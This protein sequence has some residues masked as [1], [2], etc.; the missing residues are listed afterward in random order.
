MGPW[1]L[2]LALRALNAAAVI[3]LVLWVIKQI[4]TL[5]TKYKG[6]NCRHGCIVIVIVIVDACTCLVAM[7]PRKYIF[8]MLCLHLKNYF[9]SDAQKI[10]QRFL[11][12]KFFGKS[13]SVLCAGVSMDHVTLMP[14]NKSIIVQ[15]TSVVH[16]Q[17]VYYI[18]IDDYI[19]V[20]FFY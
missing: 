5:I 17:K 2:G 13:S 16:T 19:D 12:K 3:H 11:K 15:Y 9:Q 14:F 7:E 8:T 20:V 18:Y 4:T 10:F 1:V 6:T